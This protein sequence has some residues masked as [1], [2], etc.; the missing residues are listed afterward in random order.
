MSG[1]TSNVPNWVNWNDGQ[2]RKITNMQGG[3]GSGTL[4]WLDINLGTS[5]ACTGQNCDGT[6]NN[7]CCFCYGDIGSE[8]NYIAS[9]FTFRENPDYLWGLDTTKNQLRISPNPETVTVCPTTLKTPDSCGTTIRAQNCPGQ[10]SNWN[11]LTFYGTGSFGCTAPDVISNIRVTSEDNAKNVSFQPYP[12][13]ALLANAGK[14]T[15]FANSGIFASATAGTI[16]AGGKICT[17]IPSGAS[18]RGVDCFNSLPPGIPQQNLNNIAFSGESTNATSYSV[19][20]CDDSIIAHQITSNKYFQMIDEKNAFLCCSNNAYENTNETYPMCKDSAFDPTTEANFCPTIA[21]SFCQDNFGTSTQNGELCNQ[22]LLNSPESGATVQSTV[23]NYL[24]SRSPQNYISPIVAKN[25]PQ[26]VSANFY[27]SNP[28]STRDDSTDSFF[29]Q[30]LPYLCT[31]T[32]DPSA[33]DS[34][35]NRFCYEFSR[36]DITGNGV[37]NGQLDTTLANVCGCH[38][39]T[40]SGIPPN[41][42]ITTGNTSTSFNL[43]NFPTT[44][45]PNVYDTNIPGGNACDPICDNSSISNSGFNT[46]TQDSCVIDNVTVNIY[47]S[48]TG[49]INFSQDCSGSTCYI[50]DVSINEINSSIGSGTLSQNCSACYKYT[51]N[52]LQT[53]EQV[54]CGSLQPLNGSGTGNGNGSGTGNGNGNGN[55][56]T[57]TTQSSPFIVWFRDHKKEFI[58][59]VLLVALLIAGIVFG[60]VYSSITETPTKQSIGDPSTPSVYSTPNTSPS[61]SPSVYST[62]SVYSHYYPTN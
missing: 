62:P 11:Y 46:C 52:N 38:L 35:L 15:V 61:V 4:K 55:N 28:N 44:S 18:I 30:T 45:L 53:A 1:N 37:S 59:I 49:S 31:T 43:T 54:D 57:S 12:N 41:P 7:D 17:F 47:N 36:N 39:S 3:D 16:N 60:L 24:T 29:T 56:G 40:G 6:G 22:Y 42:I 5:S 23:M 19:L 27:A 58:L 33:C 10:S 8:G 14:S 2:T 26:S 25:N 21:Q 20:H 50:G 51:D 9:S 48:S 34:I 32:N 13:T